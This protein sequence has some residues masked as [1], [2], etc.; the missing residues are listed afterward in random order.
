MMYAIET[1]AAFVMTSAKRELEREWANSLL[2]RQ[3]VR[4]SSLLG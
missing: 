4:L 2:H 3:M 1:E